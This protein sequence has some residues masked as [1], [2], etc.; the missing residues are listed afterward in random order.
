VGG[1]QPGPGLEQPT[2]ERCGQPEGRVGDHVVRLA[3]EP[4]RAG[5][6]LD[7]DDRVAESPAQVRGAAR[8]GLDGDDAGAGLE[9]RPGERAP[10]GADVQDE[11]AGTDAG[12]SDEPVGPARVELVPS[13]PRWRGHGDAP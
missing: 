11:V 5:I 4:E 10:A 7:H 13:P 8:M 3:G 2:Q 12:V 9:Q 1:H 6:G